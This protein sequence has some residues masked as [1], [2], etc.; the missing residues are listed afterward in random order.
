MAKAK[1]KVKARVETKAKSETKANAKAKAEADK[2]AKESSDESNKPVDLAA[3][4]KEI[5]NIVG[6]AATILT[7]AVVAEGKKGQLGPVKY[8]FEVAGLYPAPEESETKPEEASLARTLLHRLGLPEEPVIT[9]EDERPLTLNLTGDGNAKLTAPAEKDSDDQDPRM[10]R[11]NEE[12]Q[13]DKASAAADKT[14]RENEGGD[15]GEEGV[16]VLAVAIP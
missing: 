5:S 3:V 13:N 2:V 16:T 9:H 10:E 12:R 7:K 8:L 11:D 1:T 4:R 6:N 15:K 14:E